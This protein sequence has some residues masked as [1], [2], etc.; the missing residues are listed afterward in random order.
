MKKEIR[1]IENHVK[2]NESKGDNLLVENQFMTAWE[3][4]ASEIIINEYVKPSI[5][6]E[7]IK[8]NVQTILINVEYLNFKKKLRY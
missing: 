4:D 3:T 1:G 8:S 2:F 5:G 6:I 7:M